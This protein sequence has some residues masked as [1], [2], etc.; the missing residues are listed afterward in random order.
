MF[1]WGLRFI[2][3]N[4]IKNFQGWNEFWEMFVKCPLRKNL[5]FWDG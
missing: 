5:N 4:L 2:K 1:E 3:I